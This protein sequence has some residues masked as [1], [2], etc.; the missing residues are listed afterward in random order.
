MTKIIFY[1]AAL[2][3][4]AASSSAVVVCAF[5]NKQ[6]KDYL[7]L[8]YENIIALNAMLFYL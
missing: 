5:T 1:L 2:L 8:T 7:N 3:Y 6:K 4:V